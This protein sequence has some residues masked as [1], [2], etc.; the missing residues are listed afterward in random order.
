ML[1]SKINKFFWKNSQTFWMIM[2]KY[3]IKESLSLNNR[4]SFYTEVSLFG[5]SFE[6]NYVSRST[7]QWV[8]VAYIRS[9]ISLSLFGMFDLTISKPINIRKSYIPQKKALLLIDWKKFW[10]WKNF[11]HGR[12]QTSFSRS[13][14]IF[15]KVY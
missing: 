9:C 5:L 4:L 1:F 10:N 7:I 3:L 8:S 6:V 2:T 12:L 14:T 15:G 13:E 11:C